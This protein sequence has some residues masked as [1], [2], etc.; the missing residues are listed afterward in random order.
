MSP[1]AP[2]LQK[3]FTDQLLLQRQASP[4]TIAAYRDT[5]RMLLG[6]ISNRKETRSRDSGLRQP[7]R[8]DDRSVP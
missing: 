6:F 8:P 4:A 2:T 7:R 5:Y 3:F 1:L